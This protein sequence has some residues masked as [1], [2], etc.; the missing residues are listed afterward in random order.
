MPEKVTTQAA[1][2][3]SRRSARQSIRAD[4]PHPLFK[5]VLSKAIGNSGDNPSKLRTVQKGDTL[6][7]LVLQDLKERGLRI[8]P[9]LLYR[10]VHEVARANH[11]SNPDLIFPG[12]EIVFLDKAQSEIDTTRGE[13]R[14]RELQTTLNGD[15]ANRIEEVTSAGN[16]LSCSP[17]VEVSD[18]EIDALSEYITPVNGDVSSRYGYRRHPLLHLPH[19]HRGVDVAAPRGTPV[20]AAMTGV[21]EYAGWKAGYGRTVIIRHP[22]NRKSLY[23]HLHDILVKK[24]QSITRS[25]RIGTVGSTG[26]STGPHLHFELHENGITVDPS[27]V[28]RNRPLLAESALSTAGR[29]PSATSPP[30]EPDG[31]T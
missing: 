8:T 10:E 15:R 24:G 26:R 16:D 12:Q 19:F 25:E 31:M 13:S 1:V 20:Q 18:P 9:A 22:E 28:L 23:A 4:S 27:S 3:A 7:E 2:V 30:E 17:P 11:L 14:I 29:N 6:S 21:V 5:E